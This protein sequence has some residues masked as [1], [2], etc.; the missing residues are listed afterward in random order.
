MLVV[1][2]VSI[3]LIL[4]NGP[5]RC[6]KD[7][8]GQIL[9]D[10]LDCAAVD[11]FARVVKERCHAA[12][13][14]RVVGSGLVPPHDYFEGV[15]DEPLPA[16]LGRT[17]RECYKAFSEQLYKP[18]HGADVFG[19]LLLADLLGADAVRTWI[20][21][22]SGFRAEAEPLIEHF[23]ARAT[24]LVR[25]HREGCMFAGD[26]RSYLDLSDL[27]VTTVDLVNPGTPEGLRRMLD[28]TVVRLATG[29]V[30]TL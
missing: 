26:S 8:S 23:G 2:A 22:D 17:P 14:M 27:G 29:A 7:T 15:K 11:K 13:G 16:F 1:G 6:G 9:A 21:T 20:I 18:L 25:L 3:R 10:A 30:R 24:L 28:R 5:P 4:L 12:Y 19:R